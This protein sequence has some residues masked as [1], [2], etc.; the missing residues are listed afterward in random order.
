MYN[1]QS[2]QIHRDRKVDQWLPGAGGRRKCGVTTNGYRFYK[3]VLELGN[4]DG[5]TTL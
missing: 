4:G 3:N 1:G 2:R 5:C